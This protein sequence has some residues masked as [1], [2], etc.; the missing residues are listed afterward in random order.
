M[1]EQSESSRASNNLDTKKGYQKDYN[2]EICL[3]KSKLWHKK[4]IILKVINFV[5]IHADSGSGGRIS[6][7][8][9]SL[10]QE[11]EFMRLNFFVIFHEVKIHNNYSISWLRH[12]S[13]DRNSKKALLGILISWSF[14]RLANQSWD[15]NLI[16]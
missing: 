4:K 5:I 6:W 8:Q 16:L 7:A 14:L 15:W 9:N 11:I 13:W 10:F 2:Y 1:W 12:F 3:T